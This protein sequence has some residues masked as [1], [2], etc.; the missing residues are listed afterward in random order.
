MET[1]KQ[2]DPFYKMK[3]WKRLRAAVLRRDG[4]VCQIC[5]RYGRMTSADTAHHAL[6]RQEWPAYEWQP[7]NLVSLCGACHDEMHDRNTGALTEK[8]RRLQERILR[9][10]GKEIGEVSPRVTV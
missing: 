10:A 3:R 8:G 2:V 1:L 6:P 4:Y 9:Q 5:K 7:W